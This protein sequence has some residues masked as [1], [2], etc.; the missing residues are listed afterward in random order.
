MKRAHAVDSERYQDLGRYPESTGRTALSMGRAALSPQARAARSRAGTRGYTIIELAVSLGIFLMLATVITIAVARSLGAATSARVERASEAAMSNELTKMSSLPYDKLVAGTFTVPDPCPS[1]PSGIRGESCVKAGAATLRIS[2]QFQD[3][4]TTAGSG[5]ADCSPASNGRRTSDTFGYVGLCADVQSVNG[6]TL[7]QGNLGLRSTTKVTAPSPVYRSDNGVLRVKLTGDWS[8]LSGSS[9]FLVK[10]ATP[11]VQV[12]SA[13]VLSDTVFLS[14]PAAA[15][16]PVSQTCTSTDPCMLALNPGAR[17]TMSNGVALFGSTAAGPGARLVAS[18]GAITETT[19]EVIKT[20]R[21]NLDL[22]AKNNSLT[23]LNPVPGSVCLWAT[24]PDGDLKRTVPACNTDDAGTVVLNTYDPNWDKANS[25]STLY[26]FP[27]GVPI[28]VSADHPDG[29]CYRAPGMLGSVPGAAA[30]GAAPADWAPRAVCT[31]FTWGV[32]T[33]LETPVTIPDNG[34]QAQRTVSWDSA[35]SAVT[36]PAAG[37]PGAGEVWAK[38]RQAPGC[39]TD[40]TCRTVADVSLEPLECDSVNQHCFS[41]GNREPAV[42]E[43]ASRLFKNDTVG[44]SQPYHVVIDDPE[45]D[46][47]TVKA[48]GRNL[49]G[50]LDWSTSANGTY[51]SFGSSGNTLTVKA[52]G[53]VDLWFKYTRAGGDTTL[54]TFDLVLSDNVAGGAPRTE[55]IGL[56]YAD[57]PWTVTAANVTFAQGGTVAVSAAVNSTSGAPAAGQAL[58][59]STASSGF[60]LTP[61]ATATTNSSGV[62]TVNLSGATVSA[63]T[64]QFTATTANGRSSSFTVTVTPAAGS[65]TLSATGGAQATEGT[66]S[67]TAKDRAG[68]AMKGVVITLSASAGTSTDPSDNVF[69]RYAGCVTDSAGACSVP[70]VI[71]GSAKAGSYTVRAGSGAYS[72]SRV[73]TVTQAPGELRTSPSDGAVVA[74]GD[75][76]VPTPLVLVDKSGDPLASADVTFTGVTGISLSPSVV[77]SKSDGTLSVNVS[78]SASKSAGTYPVSG[79]VGSTTL[80]FNVKVKVSANSLS[81]SAVSLAQESNTV[82]TVTVADTTGNPAPAAM[83]RF[84]TQV[85]GL[86]IDSRAVTD[87][88]GTARVNLAAGADV[89]AGSY[90]ITATVADIPTAIPVTVTATPKTISV[91]GALAQGETAQ[92][93][94]VTVRDSAGDTIAA[95]PLTLSWSTPTLV[96]S[97][98]SGKTDSDGF[99]D[100]TVNDTGP[101]RAGVYLLTSQAENLRVDI[102]V[103]LTGMPASVTAAPT[104][105][106]LTTNTTRTVTVTVIDRA[107]DPLPGA[108]VSASLPPEAIATTTGGPTNETGRTTLTFS[109]G[110]KVSGRQEQIYLS[111]VD[112]DVHT[113]MP[114]AVLPPATNAL[115]TLNPTALWPMDSAADTDQGPADGPLYDTTFT[116][117]GNLTYHNGARTDG[118][119]PGSQYTQFRATPATGTVTKAT[120]LTVPDS[121][122][123]LTPATGSFTVTSW[124]RP[125]SLVY[126]RAGIALSKGTLTP[127]AKGPGFAIGEGSSSTSLQVELA[128]GANGIAGLVPLPAGKQVTDWVGKWTQVTV[129]YDRPAGVARV[130]VNGDPVGTTSIASVTGSVATPSP[131]VVGNNSGWRTDGGVDD[132]AIYPT[133]LTD[134]QVYALYNTRIDA[135]TASVLSTNPVSYYK[136]GEVTGDA[137]DYG[138]L[139]LNA[140]PVPDVSAVDSRFGRG[141]P[142]LVS[143]TDKS[144]SVPGTGTAGAYLA[145]PNSPRQQGQEFTVSFW[146]QP[147]NTDSTGYRAP[148][149]ARTDS[150]NKS[151]WNVYVAPVAAGVPSEW[152]FWT[153]S[154]TSWTILPSGVSATPGKTVFVT[155]TRSGGTSRFY[156]NGQLVKQAAMPFTASTNVLSIGAGLA[157]SGWAGGLDEVALYD[158]ALPETDIRRMYD[159]GS[160][161]S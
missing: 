82:V 120:E 113:T 88:T 58:T 7:A 47:V 148:V 137:V 31:S 130:Y 98:A 75:S 124:V 53:K 28:R 50:Q 147:N 109:S 36:V 23:A 141:V 70:L 158:Y 24:F 90:T 123:T 150:T 131:L 69:P 63:G 65:L 80:P 15:S 74:Q 101:T 142:G 114:F 86:T 43:P 11:G 132:T 118:Y 138:Q 117:P 102:P 12:A 84:A 157:S 129:V 37:Y 56:Y 1:T 100:F 61:S 136:L 78:A 134:G 119:S 97:P 99:F 77:R 156:L 38:P 14:V 103:T 17:P 153:G 94:S 91:K 106:S 25:G 8:N 89:R 107:G 20:G 19:A 57:A 13:Q 55:T 42:A 9:L 76:N 93:L 4:S 18:A 143:G 52:G 44:A 35:N 32:P 140:A 39:A 30:S 51:T 151:G 110:S 26:P 139:R 161:S 105:V 115:A 27:P 135:K 66:I 126:P 96:A 79:R 152:Q 116:R 59:F 10:T 125:E 83:V 40:A 95:V 60:S 49:A 29:V 92:R 146:A 145:A 111:T 34:G 155:V 149:F 159:D 160:A 122:A 21:A 46:T 48:G 33:G 154:G 72:T 128:D 73:V 68:A 108:E 64:Y 45:G 62:A 71:E 144:L 87:A 22:F 54:R 85:N 127:A 112:G 104:S 81:S 67:A 2:Y 5:S 16:T 133:A 41:G 121:G 6:T 3:L